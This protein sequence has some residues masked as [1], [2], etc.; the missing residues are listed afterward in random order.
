M[1]AFKET[2]SPCTYLFA[3][4]LPPLSQCVRALCRVSTGVRQGGDN[5][6]GTAMTG[7]QPGGKKMQIF[8]E[9][10]EVKKQ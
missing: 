4:W 5:W 2:P 7:G 8:D 1:Y 6:E 10:Q 9:N 3:F